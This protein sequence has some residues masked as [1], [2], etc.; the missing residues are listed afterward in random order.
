[1][2]DCLANACVIFSP[3]HLLFVQSRKQRAKRTRRCEVLLHLW[4]EWFWQGTWR[5]DLGPERIISNSKPFIG[6]PWWLSGKESICNARDP[7][8]ASLIPGLGRSPGGGHRNPLQ[9][10]CLEN[11]MDKGAWW[12]PVHRV[13]KSWTLMKWLSMYTQALYKERPWLTGFPL[14]LHHQQSSHGALHESCQMRDS[15]SEGELQSC[16]ISW[17]C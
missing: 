13:A 9:Y 15:W 7:G 16:V 11:T 1:M 8:D 4:R 14:L 3:H 2:P 10:S 12:A 17:T 6:L 5:K